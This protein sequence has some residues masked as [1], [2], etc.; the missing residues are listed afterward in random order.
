MDAADGGDTLYVGGEGP[1]NYTKIQDAIENANDGDTIFV[2][3][4]TYHENIVINK[5]INLIGE[6]KW[7]T[8]I[9]AN[10]EEKSAINITASSVNISKFTILALDNKWPSA[11]IKLFRVRDVNISYCDI[12]FS[13]IGIYLY[14]SDNNNI[15]Y[16]DI[17]KN[18][19]GIMLSF[20]TENSILSCDI[21]HSLE[22]GFY[23]SASDGNILNGCEIYENDVGGDI[24]GKQ[25]ILYN[26]NITNNKIGIDIIGYFNEIK[27]CNI[28]GNLFGVE[29]IVA[30]INRI[31]N[32][33]FCENE[34]NAF[35]TN[36]AFNVWFHNYWKG[37]I[38]PLPKPIFG[39]LIWS[40][41]E[42]A[43]PW[44]NFDW[45]PRLMPYEW[46]SQ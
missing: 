15:E 9:M 4:G 39:F 30:F 24:S 27:A 3:N 7:D 6:I 21:H 8:I 19:C 31:I 34:I 12:Y 29:L 13:P 18:N 37:W 40:F 43:I 22:E 44:L 45:C 17:G 1:G 36:A 23:L 38:S 46:W 16:C 25:N 11:G 14:A 41:R 32:N 35:F 26:C 28:C 33:N 2:Y 42:M 10:E 5:S 20:S